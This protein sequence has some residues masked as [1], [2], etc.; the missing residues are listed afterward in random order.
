MLADPPQLVGKRV[1]FLAVVKN[2]CG[3][4]ERARARVW[5]DGNIEQYYN[6]PK[7]KSRAMSSAVV[8][9]LV[10]AVGIGDI[11]AIPKILGIRKD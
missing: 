4:V 1:R 10:T 6:A 2:P 5:A 11:E 7:E 8:T 9:A 3:E